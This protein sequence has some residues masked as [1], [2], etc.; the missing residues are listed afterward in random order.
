MLL[1]WAAIKGKMK[2]VCDLTGLSDTAAEFM[3]ELLKGRRYDVISKLNYLLEDYANDYNEDYDVQWRHNLENTSSIL[4]ALFHYMKR[5]SKYDSLLDYLEV[6]DP[7]DYGIREVLYRELLI[8]RIIDAVK[9]GT[10]EYKEQHKPW[11]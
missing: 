6:Y 4:N 1:V 5:Y 3:S 10:E 9:V 2:T 11:D 8:R 7:K